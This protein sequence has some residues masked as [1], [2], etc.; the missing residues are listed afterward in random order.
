MNAKRNLIRKMVSAY[1]NEQLELHVQSF[2]LLCIASII[3]GI[4]DSIQSAFVNAGVVV[5][6][7]N[8][9]TSVIASCMLYIVDKKVKYRWCCWIFI[10]SVFFI[11]YPCM[12]FASGGIRG[13]ITC[14]M[15]MAIYFTSALLDQRDSIIALPIEFALYL[16]CCVAG[17]YLPE[18]S[19]HFDN[20]YYLGDMITGIFVAGL[21]LVVVNV[22]Q[23]H[24]NHRRQEQ[25]QEFSRELYARNEALERY[26]VMK[27]DFLAVVAHEISTPLAVIEASSK[28]VV[29]LLDEPE[30]NLVEIIENHERIENRVILIDR[31]VTDLMDVVAIESGRLALAREPIRLS[32]LIERAADA[33]SKAQNLN[34]NILRYDLQ[35]DLPAILADPSRI[36]Q[37]MTNLLAN[38]LRSTVNGFVTVTLA[39]EGLR[40][41][42]SVKDTGEGMDPDMA[43]DVFRRYVSTSRERW[44][45]GIGLYICRQIV[46]SHGGDIWIN[47]EKGKGTTVTFTLLEE[48]DGEF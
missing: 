3:T 31:I 39:R 42:I 44:R 35:P 27:S 25:I 20:T 37:V 24:L 46:Q 13:G 41:I 21:T 11:A 17:Y 45:H 19:A 8:L 1:F 32:E 28:D 14:Y 29:A 40:Q 2:H 43:Q 26:D 22:L 47:S 33:Q 10:V 5:V 38:A 16:S 9:S 4:A 12:F 15:V 23:S 6:L 36:E 7:L 30:A 18:L 48:T 34:G